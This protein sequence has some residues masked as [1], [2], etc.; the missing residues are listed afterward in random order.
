MRVELKVERCVME[1]GWG[2]KN[3]RKRRR[4]RKVERDKKERR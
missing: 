4:E 3:E 2:R 1:I